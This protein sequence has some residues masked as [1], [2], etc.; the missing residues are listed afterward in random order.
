[1]DRAG[2]RER[3]VVLAAPVQAEHPAVVVDH[4]RPGVATCGEPLA[5]L[6][7]L[8]P[9][10]VAQDAPPRARPEVDRRREVDR[11]DHPVGQP[12]G[13]AVLADACADLRISPAGD[14]PDADDAGNPRHA[15]CQRDHRGVHLVGEHAAGERTHPVGRSAAVGHRGLGPRAADVLQAVARGDVPV[16]QGHRPPG[17]GFADEQPERAVDRAQPGTLV[18]GRGHRV[19]RA[20]RDA[21]GQGAHA[22]CGGRRQLDRLQPHMVDDDVRRDAVDRGRQRLAGRELVERALHLDVHDDR[23]PARRRPAAD[24]LRDVDADDARAREQRVLPGPL[25]RPDVVAGPFARIPLHHWR[26]PPA[27]LCC[28]RAARSGR[29]APRYAPHQRCDTRHMVRTVSAPPDTA[30]HRATRGGCRCSRTAQPLVAW[31]GPPYLVEVWPPAEGT[32][33]GFHDE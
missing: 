27:R 29:P 12:R 18:V 8:D 4:H 24:L 5:A 9:Q 14:G 22:L 16:R 21:A 3:T 31:S 25:H 20:E 26:A 13:P 33:E 17:S 32:G 11:C 28:G 30:L 6:G 2:H 23:Q 15:R 1:M 10:L 7:G 19:E